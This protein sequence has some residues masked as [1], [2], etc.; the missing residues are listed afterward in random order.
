MRKKIGILLVNDDVGV[1][2]YLSS[3]T[4]SLSFL[5][6]AQQPEIL[7]LY[8]SVCKKYLDFYNYKYL[9][10]IEIKYNKNKKLKYIASILLQSNILIQ[11]IIKQH[12]L[13]GLFPVMD[14]PVRSRIK[15]CTIASWIPDFQHKFYPGFFTKNNLV[16]R[17]ARFKK[18]IANCD[19]MVLSSNDANSHLKQ[20]YPLKPGRP[21]IIVM[22]FVSMIRNFPI[23]EFAV[24]VDKYRISKPYF[25]VSNQFYAHKNHMVVLQ[26]IKKLKED[27]LSFT[28]YLTGK[29][30]DY[31]NPAFFATLV[32]FI[33]ENG[34]E[35]EAKILGLIPRED[36]LG[37]L[38][39]ALAIVQPSK[40]EGWS[41]IIEDAK[42]LQRQI[43]CSNIDVHREQMGDK[44]FYFDSDDVNELTGFMK[45]FLTDGAFLKPVFNNYDERVR[46]FASTF[47]GMF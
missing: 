8:D 12:K 15:N 28:V 6:D 13:D 1:A 7:L 21:K 25:L 14:L 22:P 19:T 46:E 2:Y 41:T 16:L 40:F 31:R 24:L 30:E 9:T 3:I 17:E 39:R 5:D 45:R 11:P 10:A 43:I 47:I 35:N 29:T 18:T 42:T 4:K 36:Q 37:L 44:A 23:T 33:E 34:L 26:A 27:G 38:Q 20:F 32:G